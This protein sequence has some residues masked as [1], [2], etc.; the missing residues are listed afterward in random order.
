M[1]LLKLGTQAR[2]TGIRARQGLAKD[3]YDM[4]DVDEF[5]AEDGDSRRSRSSLREE[6]ELHNV[7]RRIDFTDA[8]A[9]SF[10]LSPIA[11]S[12]G[13][14]NRLKKS[15]LRSPLQAKKFPT[16]RGLLPVKSV[17]LSKLPQ[18]ELYT[19]ESDHG[20]YNDDYDVSLS[21]GPPPP[22]LPPVTETLISPP[23]DSKSPS[24]KSTSSLTK[25]MA[26]GPTK[27][28][29]KPRLKAPPR[30]LIQPKEIK[31]KPSPLPSP[32]PD[33]LRR[34]RR[35]KI[36]P[37]AFWRNERIVYSRA[38]DNE[39]DPDTTLISDIRK[40]PL[41][42]IKEVV[43]IPE[44]VSAG[45]HK[46]RT[47]RGRPRASSKS[48]KLSPKTATAYDYE[49]D[50]EI[51]GSEWF[52]DKVKAISVFTPK[53]EATEPQQLVFAPDYGEFVSPAA[54]DDS[55]P[56]TYKVATL[57]SERSAASGLLDFPPE[58]FRSLRSSPDSIFMCHVV[59][60]LLE[61]TISN[62][63]FVVTKGCSF[64][65]PRANPYSFRNIGQ[66]SARIFFV[67]VQDVDDDDNE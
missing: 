60:G 15:P 27:R 31:S 30:R 33:G 6:G 48:R 22:E 50:P 17:S 18:A 28:T 34:S 32:P 47:T 11:L 1:D 4:E 45:Q 21:P 55:N 37:L 64:Q 19:D 56:D 5:F 26:L 42:E 2:K 10:K 67:Q 51:T 40:I 39:D 46:K 14:A 43:H 24:A 29:R 59:K 61:I 20:F 3:Q 65:I 16:G 41:Q 52:Q 54:G 36:A 62:D 66:D 63:T 35:T 25:R 8:E 38:L 49:S 53:G 23:V 57:F 12:S 13:K 44:Q 9:E 7:A 58:G